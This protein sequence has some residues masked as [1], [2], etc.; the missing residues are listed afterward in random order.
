MFAVVRRVGKDEI[1]LHLVAAEKSVNVRADD[2]QFLHVKLVGSFTDELHATEVLVDGDDL[3]AA[4]R[5]QLIGD[6]ARAGKQVQSFCV[7]KVEVVFDNVKQA[8]FSHIGGG[9][10]GQVVG[11]DDLSSLVSSSDNSHLNA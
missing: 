11:R 1:V 4:S 8:L 7:F 10:H 2:E 9:S 6:V 3:R 5:D